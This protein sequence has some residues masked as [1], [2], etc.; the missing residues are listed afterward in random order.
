[1]KVWVTFRTGEEYTYEQ[2]TLVIEDRST[3]QIC[4]GD[5]LL[6]LLDKSSLQNW[7][8]RKDEEQWMK[9]NRCI[10]KRS[11]WFRTIC[12][13]SSRIISSIRSPKGKK[14]GMRER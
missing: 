10:R 12:A 5:T 13:M 8:L 9:N 2:V 11:G 14:S 4:N 6:A 1:M 7:L 3:I